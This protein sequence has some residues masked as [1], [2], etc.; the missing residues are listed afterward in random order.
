MNT[1]STVSPCHLYGMRN[2]WWPSS[3]V[4]HSNDS[5]TDHQTRRKFTTPTTRNCIIVV[6]YSPLA[7][8]T[9]LRRRWTQKWQQRDISGLAQ[10]WPKEASSCTVQLVRQLSDSQSR[11]PVVFTWSSTH[12]SYGWLVDGGWLLTVMGRDV[13]DPKSLQR[14]K[15]LPQS[16]PDKKHAKDINH[17][18]PRLFVR[19][20]FFFKKYVVFN[21]FSMFTYTWCFGRVPQCL[22][23]SLSRG[24]ILS[25]LGSCHGANSVAFHRRSRSH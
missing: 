16:A 19:T 6:S 15:V 1:V 22:L 7:L 8:L 3:H 5:M 14:F 12:R 11:R 2:Q 10:G 23:I 21:Y 4:F 25:S 13:P 24:G 20:L 18:D 9:S 17:T